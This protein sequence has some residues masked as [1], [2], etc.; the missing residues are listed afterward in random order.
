M[1]K[2]PRRVSFFGPRLWW[3]GDNFN[4]SIF[5]M[6]RPVWDAHLRKQLGTRGFYIKLQARDILNT[7]F[8]YRQ[9]TDLNGR[10]TH[11]EDIIFRF[12][13]GS[14]WSLTLGWQPK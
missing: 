1:G 5:E 7:P 10:I 8:V 4:P 6:P 3:V 11:N 13:R 12:V 2:L 9:D 14:E